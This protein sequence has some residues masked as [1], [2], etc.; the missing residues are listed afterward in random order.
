MRPLVPWIVSLGL[1]GA[2]ATPFTLPLDRTDGL[3]PVVSKTDRGPEV[4]TFAGRKA[5]RATQVEAPDT[6]AV[7][8][9]LLLLVPGVEFTD[10][11]IDVDVVGRPRAGA[12]SDVRGFVGVA[13][14]IQGEAE[15][16]ECFYI[17]QTNGRADDQVRRNHSTQYV[18][19]PEW[20]WKRLRDEFPAAYES[21]V[22]LALDTW[23]HLRIHV[24]GTRA[25][26]YVGNAAQ[27]VLIVKDLRHGLAHGRVGLWV[28]SD[29]EAYFSQL[30]ISR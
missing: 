10:G 14:R 16:Y 28:G 12:P 9:A 11:T 23:T 24:A 7:S 27:P 6:Q 25:E 1:A 22:D 3:Q 8:S 2:P 15:R 17:R 4:V 29:T 30:K 21:Y 20:S 18:S 19:E 5:V 13:F 26:L